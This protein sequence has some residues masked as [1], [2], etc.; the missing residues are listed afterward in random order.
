MFLPTS[1][2][3]PSGMIRML[4]GSSWHQPVPVTREERGLADVRDADRLRH[5]ALEA[6]GEAAVR[7]HPV[8]ER[9]EVGRERHGIEPPGG[10]RRDVVVVA[11]QALAACHDLEAAVEEGE[12]PRPLRT[13]RDG[14]R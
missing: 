11:V 6:E 14:M 10:E 5:E 9:V 12:A 1:P 8:A 7:R 4:T 13:L 2:S 3:P